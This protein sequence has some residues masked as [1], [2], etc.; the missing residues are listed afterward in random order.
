MS[1]YKVFIIVDPILCFGYSLE[2]PHQDN[3]NECPQHRVYKRKNVL[4]IPS[5]R[6]ICMELTK[7]TYA[8]SSICFQKPQNI[9]AKAGSAFNKQSPFFPKL[10]SRTINGLGKVVSVQNCITTKFLPLFCYNHSICRDYLNRY[11]CV[12]KNLL[13]HIAAFWCTKDI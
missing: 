9:A 2:L 3:S 1:K 13:P 6:L 7:K 5:L 11:I 10:F 8:R 12:S 4:W